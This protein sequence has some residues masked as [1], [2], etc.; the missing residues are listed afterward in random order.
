[1]DE[2]ILLYDIYDENK[3]VLN[4]QVILDNKYGF[5]IPSSYY[6]NKESTNLKEHILNIRNDNDFIR[7][8]YNQCVESDYKI[9]VEEIKSRHKITEDFTNYRG[10]KIIEYEDETGINVIVYDETIVIILNSKCK[11]YSNEY[12]VLYYIIFS[13]DS[14]CQT[15]YENFYYQKNSYCILKNAKHIYNN[16]KINLIKYNPTESLTVIDTKNFCEYISENKDYD[17]KLYNYYVSKDKGFKNIVD[18][19]KDYR[20]NELDDPSFMDLVE[21]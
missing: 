16:Y 11:K 9:K 14:N 7:M 18:K 17:D 10:Q 8:Y 13:F 15:S 20:N 1:M 12:Y 5:E 2:S 4:S 6:F 19:I 3:N 21:E